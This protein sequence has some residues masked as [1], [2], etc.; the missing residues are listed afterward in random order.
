VR[1]IEGTRSGNRKD[2]IQVP[3]IEW[4]TLR[5]I[6]GTRNLTRIGH[7]PGAKDRIGNPEADRGDEKWK[8]I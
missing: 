7:N 8:P 2:T 4:Q 6:E 3:K 1:K 5:K